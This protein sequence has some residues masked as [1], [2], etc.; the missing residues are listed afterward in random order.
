MIKIVIRLLALSALFCTACHAHADTFKILDL[1]SS[2]AVSGTG[3]VLSPS[4][5]VVGYAGSPRVAAIDTNGTIALLG[6]LS[7]IASNAFGINSMA[8]GINGAGKIV[9]QSY[10]SNI[11]PND[12]AFLYSNGK[13]TDLGTLGGSQSSA[14]GINN[15]GQVVGWADTA[16]GNQRAFIDTNGKMLSLGSLGGNSYAYSIND[17][18]QVVGY[19]FVNGNV[20]R[21][22]IYASGVMTAIGT[23]GG[24]SYA[25]EINNSGQVVGWSS[26]AGGANHA[27]LYSNGK[28]TDLGSLGGTDSAALG[29]NNIGQV[30]GWSLTGSGSYHAFL[31][32]NGSMVDLNSLV[33]LP[34]GI[35]LRDASAINNAGQIIATGSNGD[36]YLLSVSVP[37]PPTYGLLVLSGFF[38]LATLIRRRNSVAAEKAI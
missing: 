7:G 3:G 6:T 5:S 38:L 23:L 35:Y 20:Q 18:S 17:N 21:A 25:D 30:V 27:F 9:G 29:I 22:F 15:G 31:D 34:Q 36:T 11:N 33:S 10:V 2:I 1:G 28:L 19:S 4:G 37:E 8:Y 32:A 16:S 13:M 14:F 24:N 26:L 12:H